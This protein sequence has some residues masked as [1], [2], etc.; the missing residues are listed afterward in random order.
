MG[1]D[2]FGIKEGDR[3][4]R[5]RVGDV[6]LT[7]T[8]ES[9]IVDFDSILEATTVE[10]DDDMGPPWKEHDGWEHALK[11]SD[12]LRG[13]NEDDWVRGKGVVVVSRDQAREWGVY[14]YTPG[15]TH[16]QRAWERGERIRRKAIDQIVRWYEH[17]YTW[18]GVVCK[19]KGHRA[20]I[21][22]IQT[23]GDSP[24][25]PYLDETRRELAGE[26]ADELEKDGYTVIN[27]PPEITEAQGRR[28]RLLYRMVH[29]FDFEDPD[30]YHAWVRRPVTFPG[31][32]HHG[33]AED[34][35]Q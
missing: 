5:L 24:D 11:K 34:P 27:R 28:N 14:G 3:K 22:G 21:W 7:V 29:A 25:D 19:F 15:H 32:G 30:E 9:A 35:G 4:K 8:A 2:V 12:Y 31:E 10:V 26:V 6:M 20:S 18:Y 16:K 1:T 33:E 23:E 13:Y 17:G